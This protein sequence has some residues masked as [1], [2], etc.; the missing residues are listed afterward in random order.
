[1]MRMRSFDAYSDKKMNAE[2]DRLFSKTYPYVDRIVRNSEKP[3][4]ELLKL[5]PNPP[6]RDAP[7][8]GTG[9]VLFAPKLVRAAEVAHSRRGEPKDI[10]KSKTGPSP[11]GASSKPASGSS[12][13]P[14]RKT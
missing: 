10:S 7:K 5:H 8:A 13:G 1:M 6:P 3:V 14:P 9:G 2:F 4:Q 12:R 11:Q